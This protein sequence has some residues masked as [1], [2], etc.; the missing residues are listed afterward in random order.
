MLHYP[1]YIKIFIA[2]LAIV[3]PLGAIP[4]F[5]GLIGRTEVEQRKRIIR[6]VACSVA[7]ILLGAL[8]FGELILRFF[9]ISIHSFRVG[10]GILLLVFRQPP[11]IDKPDTAE[12]LRED[13]LLRSV[14][15]QAKLEAFLHQFSHELATFDDIS[16][17]D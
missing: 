17:Y 15:H 16:L 8:F 2:L 3:N 11:V 10:G 5:I 9:G 1:D 4:V 12:M 14:R 6:V 13:G 7:A